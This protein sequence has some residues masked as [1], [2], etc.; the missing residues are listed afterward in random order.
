MIE[1][2]ELKISAIREGTVIDHIPTK[3]TFKV[4][5]LLDV[6]AHNNVVSVATNLQSKKM[7]TKG[8][9]KVGGRNLT[10]EEANK[11]AILAPNASVA[12]IKDYNVVKKFKLKLPK[13]VHSIIQ[14]NNPKCITNMEEAPTKFTILKQ[15]PMRVRCDYCERVMKEEEIKLL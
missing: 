11:I 10:Q 5:E 9:I 7:A 2:K 6:K 13:Q 8:M 12:I 3:N 4:A 1:I 15:D 14:C